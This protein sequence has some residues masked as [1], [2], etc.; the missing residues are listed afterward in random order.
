MCQQKEAAADDHGLMEIY[1]QMMT[2]DLF[3]TQYGGWFSNLSWPL[4][5]AMLLGLMAAIS[6]GS[7]FAYLQ[8]DRDHKQEQNII[9][10][11]KKDTT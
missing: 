8:W 6:F 3:Q 10:A 11:Y 7:Y 1:R 5:V 4:L 9:S 2:V